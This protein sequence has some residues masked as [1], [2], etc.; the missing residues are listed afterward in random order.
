MKAL[1]TT[2]SLY[3][4]VANLVAHKNLTSTRAQWKD[5]PVPEISDNEILVK[6]TAVA[7]NATDFKHIDALSPPNSIVGCDYA[8]EVFKVGKGAEKLWNNG[9]RVAGA[10]HG[11]LFP[12]RGSFAE[13]LKTDA[14]LA[15]R[16]PASMDDAAATTYGVS[17]VTAALALCGRLGFPSVETLLGSG[18]KDAKEKGT[19]F[20]YAGST[21]AGLSVI[22]LAKAFGWRIVTTASPHSY[23]L[24]K[25]FGADAVF[26]YHDPDV[27]SQIAK[28]HPDITIAVDCYSEGKSTKTC[29]LV[30]GS[31]SGQVITLLPTTK[32][33]TP[34]IKHELIMAYSLFGHAFQW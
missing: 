24:V 13:Y 27:H 29:D 7:L 22:Q 1:I 30:I 15:W 9:D 18:Q 11:G 32:P 12:D 19:I 10:V 33:T 5:V 14:D 34:A 8:G 6:V 16:I 3:S 23:D 21:A 31:K 2:N 4:R 25:S 17:A 28:A 26:S 20:V